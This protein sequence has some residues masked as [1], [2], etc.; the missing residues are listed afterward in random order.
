MMIEGVYVDNTIWTVDDMNIGD[1]DNHDQRLV[2][3]IYYALPD[4]IPVYKK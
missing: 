4:D 2:P 1:A 3:D